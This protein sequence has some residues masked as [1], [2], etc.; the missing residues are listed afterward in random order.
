MVTGAHGSHVD[1]KVKVYVALRVRD[2]GM[3]ILGFMDIVDG[4]D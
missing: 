2:S 4:D 3:L 1:P